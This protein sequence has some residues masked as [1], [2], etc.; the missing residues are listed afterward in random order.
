M[1]PLLSSY[2][3]RLSAIAG[4]LINCAPVLNWLEVDN[5]GRRLYPPPPSDDADAEINTPAVAAAYAVRRYAAVASD[6]IS[7]EVKQSRNPLSLYSSSCFC[8]LFVFVFLL[9]FNW[10]PTTLIQSKGKTVSHPIR[11]MFTTEP[12][13]LLLFFFF[14]SLF[15]PS[16]RF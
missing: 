15:S 9:L 12:T 11:A 16:V 5:R 7:F 14:I 2:V 8:Y 4:N 6:E 3:S 10:F 13:F 1:K